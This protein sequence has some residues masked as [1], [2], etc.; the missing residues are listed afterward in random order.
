METYNSI[1]ANEAQAKYCKEN[2]LPHFAPTRNC[3]RCHKDIY[4]KIE[5]PNKSYITGI[6]VERAGSRLITGCPHCNYSF[7]E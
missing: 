1:K 5:Y 2:N 4:Q 7:C 3:Y 6:S